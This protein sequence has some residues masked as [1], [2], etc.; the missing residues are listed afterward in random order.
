MSRCAIS[1]E[2]IR[3]FAY[4]GVLPE[5]KS[6]GQEFL[7]DVELELAGAPRE[8]DIASTVDYAAVAEAASRLATETRHDLIE[9]LA[10]A[11]AGS[12]LDNELVIKATVTVRKPQAPMPVTVASVGVTVTAERS[13]S[14]G[15]ST[16]EEGAP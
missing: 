13:G 2:G 8:D 6:R 1:I 14:R 16:G 4:H 15:Y 3:V 5:E 10:E 9:T 7:I 11:I 12:L